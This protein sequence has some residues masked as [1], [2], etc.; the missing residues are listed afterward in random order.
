MTSAGEFILRLEAL[1]EGERSDLRKLAGKPL[2]ESLRGFDLFTG[3][4]WPLR[5]KSQAAPSREPSWLVAKLFGAF[6]IPCAWSEDQ[7]RLASVP[8]LLGHLEPSE[9]LGQDRFRRRF[10][11]LLQ[12]PLCAVEPH[13]RWG[14]SHIS[15]SRPPS[16]DW[17]QLLEDLSVWDLGTEHRRRVD[18]RQQWAKLYLTR[19][20]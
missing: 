6:P 15:R 11:G 20:A 8:H 10:D 3:L 4:W 7:A 19:T 12:A 13:L 2:D 9:P 16:L 1:G 17:V 18:V 5:E 14:L